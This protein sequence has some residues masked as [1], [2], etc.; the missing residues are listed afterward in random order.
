MDS[1]TNQKP[2]SL[3]EIFHKESSKENQKVKRS[4]ALS[5]KERISHSSSIKITDESQK[6][7][8]LKDQTS[9]TLRSAGAERNARIDDIL[10]ELLMNNLID[11]DYWKFHTM[12]MHKLGIQKYVSIVN[13][14]RNGRNPKHLLSYK[15]KGALEFAKKR[16][17]YRDKYELQ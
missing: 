5:H 2:E 12:C 8:S 9:L 11:E 17:M 3:G 15:L 10:L 6:K 13:D 4:K 14:A 16:E 7:V 1:A